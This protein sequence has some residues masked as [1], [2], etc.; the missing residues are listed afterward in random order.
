MYKNPPLGMYGTHCG[1][2]AVK[3]P[4]SVLR[5]MHLYDVLRA[6]VLKRSGCFS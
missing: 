6:R 4:F 3:C 2:R 1:R 5:S